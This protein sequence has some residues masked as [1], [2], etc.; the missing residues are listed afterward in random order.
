MTL[1]PND[2]NYVDP[3]NPLIPIDPVIPGDLGD[4]SGGNTTGD[5][6]QGISQDIPRD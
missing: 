1:D 3:N 2:P 4:A 6:S 5:S